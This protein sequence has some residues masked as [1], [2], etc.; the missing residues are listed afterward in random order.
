MSAFKYFFKKL[1]GMHQV[2][3][4]LTSLFFRLTKMISLQCGTGKGTSYI[5][6]SI[7]HTTTF[8]LWH[9]F[10][11]SPSINLSKPDTSSYYCT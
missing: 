3:C 8:K 1:A 4:F 5:L 6:F 2:F 10:S 7:Q 9:N 11:K